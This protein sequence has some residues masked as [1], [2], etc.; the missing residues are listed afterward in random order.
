MKTRL[1]SCLFLVMLSFSPLAFA[2][3]SQKADSS[4]TVIPRPIEQEKAPLSKAA[5]EAQTAPSN[6]T[7]ARLPA[8]T[9]LSFW[10]D[11]LLILATVVS[12]IFGFWERA[13]R[14]KIAR[15][16]AEMSTFGK[17]D[18]EQQIRQDES[19]TALEKY[20][21]QMQAV[22]GELK[23]LGS[24]EVDAIPVN[25]VET[26]VHL[27]IAVDEVR[28]RRPKIASREEEDNLRMGVAPS[29]V[30]R[31][32]FRRARFLVVLGDP[33]SGKTTLLQFYAIRCLQEG[34][35]KDFGFKQPVL[36]L[37]LALRDFDADLDLPGNLQ[38][39]AE[40]NELGREVSPEDFQGWLND[41]H[42]LVLLD[43]LDEIVET[44]PRR[45]CCRRIQRY[46]TA[47]K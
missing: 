23:L 36:P 2:Q 34:G 44:A 19:R 42:T 40:K 46:L 10:K 26:F 11:V 9:T 17:H 8:Q 25:L 22:L 6:P 28:E 35:Y 16:T 29:E 37:F 41:Q 5:D 21:N 1:L 18:A 45:D 13:K 20:K 47:Y 27:D 38:I 4:A 3:K 31:S 33:G 30:L 43:G 7:S 14:K 32:A 24:P 12:L 39:W 15:K